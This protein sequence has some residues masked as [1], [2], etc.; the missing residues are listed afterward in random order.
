MTAAPRI[1]VE[2]MTDR[3][4]ARLEATKQG[5]SADDLAVMT[6]KS[7]RQVMGALRALQSR[8]EI[9]SEGAGKW[10]IWRIR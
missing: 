10:R 9:I 5:L 4:A 6:G 3:I 2:A 8:N 7:I 1:Q